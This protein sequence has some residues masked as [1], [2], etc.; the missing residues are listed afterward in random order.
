M[1]R[2]TSNWSFPSSSRRVRSLLYFA[3]GLIL[4]AVLA[5]FALKLSGLF[6]IDIETGSVTPSITAAG[7]VFVV[8]GV[9]FLLRGLA[10]V[11]LGRRDFSESQP[12]W[13]DWR[14]TRQWKLVSVVAFLVGGLLVGGSV[15]VWGVWA[16]VFLHDANLLVY[17]V[18]LV[19]A[20]LHLYVFHRLGEDLV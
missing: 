3:E 4:G 5:F 1:D 20:F 2:N 6:L 15:L 8:L 10:F 19:G 9:V 12:A 13:Q 18:V 17:G 11:K 7:A 14:E 16:A